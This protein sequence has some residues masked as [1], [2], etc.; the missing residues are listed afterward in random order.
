MNLTSD[1][2]N[3]SRKNNFDFIRFLAASAV[4]YSHS[5]DIAGQNSLEPLRLFTDN[6]LTIGTL[7]LHVFFIISGFLIQQSFDRSENL[8]NYVVARCARVL[9]ALA[10]MSFAMVFLVGPLISISSIK[11]Y[12]SQDDTYLYLLNSFALKTFYHLPGVFDDNHISKL[13]NGSIWSLPLEVMFY[14]L[15]ALVG[16]FKAVKLKW[17]PLLLV[18]LFVLTTLFFIELDK[19]GLIIYHFKY[20]FTGI[21]FYKFRKKITLNYFYLIIALLICIFSLNDPMQ[22]N[23][24]FRDLLLGVTLAYII[25]C[26]SYSYSI[27]N[28]FSK[29]GDFSYGIYL[30]GF[31]VQQILIQQ[32]PDLTNIE[33]TAYAM[34][35]VLNL[36]FISW[37]FVEKP[38]LT[39]K[40]S[41]NRES[42][43]NVTVSL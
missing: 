5:F 29:Y 31:P 14:G 24:Q 20:F 3:L 38:I 40:K 13:V 4:I 17:A 27:L 28:S 41:S 23:K 18:M 10:S 2:H 39:L 15:I 11:S 32:M 12:F 8:H 1:F 7:A 43:K 42:F 16:Q 26:F 21:I 37:Y 9:P 35:I 19:L 33:L 34:P 30:W 36:A 6:Y 25:F 22:I